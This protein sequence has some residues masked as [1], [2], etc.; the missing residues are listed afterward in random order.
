MKKEHI[1]TLKERFNGYKN[2][3]IKIK[4]KGGLKE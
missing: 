1:Q 2:E 3:D 4:V